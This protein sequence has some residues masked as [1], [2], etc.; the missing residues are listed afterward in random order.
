[1]F[2]TLPRFEVLP[3]GTV[4]AR[5]GTQRNCGGIAGIHAR[6]ERTA[7][8]QFVGLPEE[9]ADPQKIEGG[10][11]P[12]R[13]VPRRLREAVLRGAKRSWEQAGM[14]EGVKFELIDALVHLTDATEMMFLV[15]GTLAMAEWIRLNVTSES[16]KH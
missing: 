3:D 9:E 2:E 13:Q 5:A 11:I 7:D 12:A 15:A 10:V 4:Y 1:V 8:Q 16:E 14:R 6:I